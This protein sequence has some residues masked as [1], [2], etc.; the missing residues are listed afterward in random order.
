VFVLDLESMVLRD[1]VVK[2]IETVEKTVVVMD[3]RV[4]G[5]GEVES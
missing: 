4:V 3:L 5:G 2:K 1:R